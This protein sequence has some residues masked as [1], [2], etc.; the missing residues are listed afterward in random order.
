MKIRTI[1]AFAL[2]IFALKINAVMAVV[3]ISHSDRVDMAYDLKRGVIYYSANGSLERYHVASSTNLAPIYIGGQLSGID[4]SADWSTVAVADR[5]PTPSD[6]K[7]HLVNLDTFAVTTRTTPREFGE[8]GS[9]AVA[10]AG[11]GSLIVTSQFQGSGWVPMR[12][13]NPESGAWTRIATVMQNTMPATSGDGKAVA[14]AEAN[15]SSGAWGSYDVQSSQV[16][17][18]EGYAAGTSWFNFE[19]GTN[20]TGSQYAIPTYGGTFIYDGTYNKIATLGAYA[21]QQPIGVVYHPVENIAY[22]PWAG[23]SEVRV[24]D[25]DNIT[26]VGTLAG[27][28]TFNL[29][30]N[31]AFVQG[32]TRI[33]R[34]GSYLMVSVSGGIHLHRLYPSL[35][36][37]PVMARTSAGEPT[38][39]LLNGYI[40]N[41]G[42]L[43]YAFVQ[44]PTNG[45]IFVDASGVAT[46][47]PS[48]GFVGTDSFRYSVRYGT[49][50]LE[51]TGTVH[52]VQPNRAPVAVGQSLSTNEDVAL[53]LGLQA[54]DADGDPLTYSILSQPLRGVLSGTGTA[55][56]Y[57]PAANFN[58]TDSF[59]FSVRDGQFQSNVATVIIQVANVND[60]PAARDDSANTVRNT[61]V[62]ISVLANDTDVDGDVLAISA[63]SSAGNGKTA[64][65]GTRIV[66][67]PANGFVGTDR[68]TYS[69]RDGRGGV[70][71]AAV[72]VVVAKK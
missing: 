2:G 70:A 44:M 43:S 68:F 24:Y 67:T 10:Y 40:G 22:F 72:T 45:T 29:T 51:S 17:R 35:S 8:G 46:Y 19:I 42:Q 26:Q 52:V 11:D 69:V 14:F 16:V 48:A 60:P 39:F 27:N 41:T 28:Q 49:A 13:L 59:T 58:G 30:G 15:I 5:L 18:R 55:R 38:Q 3:F 4:I 64:I 12:K 54:T 33:S 37:S 50:T 21:G 63:V 20:A 9:Y 47:T 66:Y 61:T 53:S 57:T 71:T 7:V 36:A 34:D 25:M 1:F 56:V 65:L 31:H 23:T 32:R 6:V 62:T